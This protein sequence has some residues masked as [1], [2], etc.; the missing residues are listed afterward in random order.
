MPLSLQIKSLTKDKLNKCCC[1][2]AYL[3]E[4]GWIVPLLASHAVSVVFAKKEDCS[5]LFC[6]DYRPEFHHQ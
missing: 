1:Q 2:I 3:L 6:Q 5:W 4:Q